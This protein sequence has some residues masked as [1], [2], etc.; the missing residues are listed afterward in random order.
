MTSLPKYHHHTKLCRNSQPSNPL[1]SLVLEMQYVF[2]VYPIINSLNAWTMTFMSFGSTTQL[3]ILLEYQRCWTNI[4]DIV[5][6][7]TKWG[8]STLEELQFLLHYPHT[9]HVFSTLILGANL[10][11]STK[12]KWKIIFV[13]FL[14]PAPSISSF[15]PHTQY[16]KRSKRKW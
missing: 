11:N 9:L 15:S 4:Y 13:F 16:W 3:I 14:S 8:P 5:I 7:T 10:L 2:F 6:S 12:S 1:S